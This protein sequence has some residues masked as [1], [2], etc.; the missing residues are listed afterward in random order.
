MNS[1]R[2]II[3]GVVLLLLGLFVVLYVQQ[4]TPN[5]PI[6]PN[7]TTTSSVI[8]PFTSASEF[9]EYLEKTIYYTYS[10]GFYTPF[11]I[12][13]AQRI[14]PVPISAPIPSV[15]REVSAPT[16]EKPRYSTT[17]VQVTGVDE[18]DIV[19]TDG[20]HIYLSS[21]YW[22]YNLNI[23]NAYPP[24]NLSFLTNIS[25]KGN[26]LLVPEK[27]VL[28]VLDYGK[29]TAYDV[30]DPKHPEKLWKI[31]INGSYVDAR[32]FNGTLYLITRKSVNYYNPCPV[33]PIVKEGIPFTVRCVDIYHP[34]IPIEV[35]STYHVLMIEPET[36]KIKHS[37][38]FVGSSRTTVYMNENHIY[39]AN[40][41]RKSEYKIFITMLKDA[42]AQ[43]V[44]PKELVDE[45]TKLDSYDII[46]Q[47]K[48]IQLQYV[49][50][51]YMASLS[52][53]EQMKLQN[54]LRNFLEKTK[55][56]YKR[57]FEKTIITKIRTNDLKILTTG[58][59]PGRLLNQFAMDEYNG[60]L[61]V[62][63]TV[64]G[65][66]WNTEGAENDLYVLDSNMNTISEVKGFG[67]DERI[68][69]V[70]FVGEKAYIVT[71]RQT[72]PFFVMDLSDPLHPKIVGE[73]KIPGYSSYLHPINETLV[74]G[75][76]KEEAYVKISLFDVS[77]P[78]NPQELD[79]YTLEEYW[80]DI[81][82]THHAFLI[83]PENK[84]FFVPGGKG[85]YVFSYKD[86]GLKLVKAVSVNNVRRALYIDHYLY[87][88]GKELVV[89]DENTWKRVN[90]L[91][92]W[93][94]EYIVKPLA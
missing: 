57:M 9:K 71:F 20:K 72:D 37:V 46:D 27:H 49:L 39:I 32:L 21:L 7:Q 30:S 75:I 25:V 80:S 18:P 23:I 52:N 44:L 17:N 48:Y 64:G 89:L 55:D 28:L 53:D 12:K 65:Q 47:A 3:G 92:L 86:N 60:Y 85:G 87:I 26:L 40:Y 6:I 70:R 41:Y 50:Q 22:R 42:G 90:E 15:L 10:T 79:K 19:K 14:G 51:K 63:V 66:W 8:K 78:E 62:A 56:K 31:D 68:Y 83:D 16:P 35:E 34:V 74:L 88:I 43:G 36:G 54:D 4:Y 58:S 59:V 93:D 5:V 1:L 69:A 81:L 82:K 13:A 45:I 33:I 76:G 29:V 67:L 24:E 2:V 11:M 38:S 73:L 84:I 94:Y 77:N 61:R 91:E